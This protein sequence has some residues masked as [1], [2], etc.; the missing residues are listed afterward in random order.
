MATATKKVYIC[1]VCGPG[2][3]FGSWRKFRGHWTATHPGEEAPERDT[4]R[5]DVEVE[6]DEEEHGEEKIRTVGDKKDYPRI[7]DGSLPDDPV[8]RLGTILDVHGIDKEVRNQVLRIFQMHPGYR[9]NP[10]NL[11]YLLTANLPRKYTSSIPMMVSEYNSQ[12]DATSEGG[13]LMLGMP[14]NQGM[15]YNPY[16]MGGY[17][18]GG[19]P[20]GG[21]PAYGVP[22]YRR[23]PTGR[24]PSDE[25]PEEDG[26]GTGRGRGGKPIDPVEQMAGMMKNIGA[27]LTAIDSVRGGKKGEEGEGNAFLEAFE[28][29]QKQMSEALDKVSE[30]IS[31]SKEETKKLMDDQ[32]EKHREEMDILKKD[33]HE[34]EVTHLQEKINE[35]KDEKD[36][37]KTT[38]LGGLIKEAGEGIGAQVDGIRKSVDTGLKD[39]T[40]IATNLSKNPPQIPVPVI[41]LSGK[42]AKAQESLNIAEASTLID[43]ESKVAGLAKELTP[44][45]KQ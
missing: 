11:H 39:I 28:E 40:G 27:F 29:S 2:K 16:M 23:R 34:K 15:G 6:K 20:Y 42:Q 44:G 14:A 26:E 24:R 7:G 30:S 22:D 31:S 41:G 18:M 38:G 5:Q 12:D 13:P 25:E 35:L 21:Y 3:T 17:G 36:D 8:D 19:S 1:P 32:E 45:T 10:V 37:E 4:V 33:I 9:N 43:A